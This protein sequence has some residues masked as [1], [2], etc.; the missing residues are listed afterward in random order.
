MVSRAYLAYV[1]AA[2]AVVRKRR[3]LGL[4]VPLSAALTWAVPVATARGL[5]RG[6][7][8]SALVWAAQMWAYKAS[9]EM[10]HDNPDRH[11][12]RTHIDYP[13]AV[14][15]VLGAGAPPSQ[16]L[17]RALRRPPALS[18]L[19]RVVSLFYMTWEVEPHV[20]LAWILLR[21][22]ERFL[23]CAIRLGATFDATLLGYFGVPTAPPW[24]ASEREG[25]LERSV[26]RV[27][28]EVI[29][30]LKDEPRPSLEHNPGANP[31]AS[32]PSDHFGSASSVAMLL[33][34]LHRGAG[35]AAWAYSLALGGALVY[36][37]EHY[38]VDLIAGLSL[39]VAVNR[40][41]RRF[42]VPAARLLIALGGG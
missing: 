8:R 29:R 13:I 31:W 33:Y 5:R 28:L 3:S 18:R 1:P 37:G 23:S 39:A 10:P 19:D 15:R 35:L 7:L 26:R 22:P 12:R 20:A 21:H 42:D 40:A 34:E 14:D 25:R 36:L 41:A 30:D 11:Y 9:F 24:W 4:P 16:R 32:M 2:V 17:Q 27:T 38:V 6:K